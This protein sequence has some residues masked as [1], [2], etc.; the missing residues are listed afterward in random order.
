MP[1][2]QDFASVSQ[3]TTRQELLGSLIA[4]A[5]KLDFPLITSMLVTE[6][7]QEAPICVP[8]SNVPAGFA[9]ASLEPTGIKRDPVISALTK[10]HLPIVYSQKTYTDAGAG[11]LWDIQAP[12]GYRSG[13]A[14]ALHLPGARHFLL[15]VDRDQRLPTG[16]KQL[17]RLLA[18][19]HLMAVHA[20]AAAVKLLKPDL[21]VELTPRE[22][23]VLRWTMRGKDAAAIAA[24]L[25]LSVHTI[26]F[27]AEN[28]IRKLGVENKHVAVT[29]ALEYGLLDP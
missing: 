3:A 7:P 9:E 18:D 15:G 25:G 12:F 24:I 20:Q 28:A 22:V 27:H 17:S 10:T 13:V 21:G 14:V 1:N 6:R 19:V 2:L 8:L 11:D 29:K 23:E 16:S 26:K 4:L 5:N